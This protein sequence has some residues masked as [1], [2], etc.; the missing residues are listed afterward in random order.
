MSHEHAGGAGER[1]LHGQQRLNNRLLNIHHERERVLA[2]AAQEPQ[3][4]AHRPLVAVVLDVRIIA[5]HILLALLI[6][7]VVGQVHASVLDAPHALVV[8]DCGE[9]SQALLVQVEDE[10]IERG[11]RHVQSQVELEALDQQ[12]VR[13]VLAHHQIVFEWNLIRLIFFFLEK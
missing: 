6:Q 7:A 1:T 13:Y 10:R 4:R 11:H 12:R 9:A 3:K 8:L 5:P 2:L